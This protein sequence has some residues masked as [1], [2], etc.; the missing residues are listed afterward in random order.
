MKNKII[1]I[2]LILIIGIFTFSV[3]LLNKNSNNNTVAT[4]GTVLSNKKIEWGIKRV[5]NHEQP[6]LGSVNKRII[7]QANR[8]SNGK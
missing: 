8:N 5:S 7:D 3:V 6:D 1:Y 2:S 4:A